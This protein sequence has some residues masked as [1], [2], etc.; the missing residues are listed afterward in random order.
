MGNF[1]FGVASQPT[2]SK[3]R[4]IMPCAAR[5]RGPKPTIRTRLLDKPKQV[6]VNQTLTLSRR[7]SSAVHCWP[8]AALERFG[9]GA[10]GFQGRNETRACRSA[11]SR[12]E[13]GVRALPG[14]ALAAR[15][16]PVHRPYAV[17][18]ARPSPNQH[19]A[20][21]APPA[22]AGTIRTLRFV[23]R[24]RLAQNPQTGPVPA[25]CGCRP[26]APGSS[27]GCGWSRA[28]NRAFPCSG[29]DA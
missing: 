28:W 15:Q 9:V 11:P 27:A 21:A 6:S 20:G 19:A 1:Q 5:R 29:R 12:A 25:R 17:D 7:W 3:E 16:T 26:S 22:L 4:R 13:M 10:L 2:R 8:F 24:R 23:R 18:S 14:R